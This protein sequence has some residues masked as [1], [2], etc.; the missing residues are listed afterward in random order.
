MTTQSVSRDPRGGNADLPAVL[1]DILG[2]VPAAAGR[3]R[4]GELSVEHRMLIDGEL[5][6]TPGRFAN[7]DPTVGSPAGEVCD[8]TPAELD[9][10]VGAARRAFLD[11]AWRTDPELRA[12][13]LR[14]L[15]E[16]LRRHAEE[17]RLAVITELGAPVRLTACVHVD[18]VIGKLGYLADAAFTATASS[19]LP[20][21][22]AGRRN[23]RRLQRVPAGVVAAI[24]PWNIPL[25]IP[26][27]KMGGALAAGNTVVLKPAPDTPL[28][29][30]LVGRVIA[31]ETDIPA[32][33]V[34]IVAS[35]DHSL[36]K[37]LVDDPRVDFISFTGATAT[38]KRVMAGAA[39]T[40]KRVHL[41]LG[42][43][44]PNVV[45]DDVDLERIVPLAAAAACF[46]AGQSC[47]LPSRLLV[48]AHSYDD[49]VELA[50]AG[51]AAVSVGDPYSPDTFM[52]PLVSFSH[53]E[54]VH[55]MV[56]D[57]LTQGGR[58]VC[59]GQPID[60]PG[61]FYPPTLIADVD[62]SHPLV[63]QELFGPVL[64]VQP[65]Q[66]EQDAIAA[67][68]GTAFGLAGYVWSA[69]RERGERI[70][71]GI[72]AGMVAINGGSITEADMPFGGV[73]QSGFGREWGQ[74]GVEEF[75][76]IKTVSRGTSIG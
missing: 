37:L 26:L 68:N 2:P 23:D 14:Q 50:A 54:R 51:M 13:C 32:G 24:T 17:L 73:K 5:V 25:D 55:A 40:L 6:S 16:G 27:A 18:E 66:D 20:D 28:A 59:G 41:E 61:F 19:A 33:V 39:D 64:V 12:R 65:Y 74:P 75:T 52:G 46:N 72:D 29:I 69:D 44:S 15:Q 11:S 31:E 71:A 35:S 67:A 43:K 49:C 63:Q 38:G 21:A 36:G 53:R 45:L 48:P 7:I 8:G 47:I 42:G 70:A 9:R 4:T 10:A 34:N 22:Q 3:L 1:L 56:A 76:E 62:R 30:N 58:L 57:G 60:G